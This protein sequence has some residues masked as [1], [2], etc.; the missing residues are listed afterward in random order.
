MKAGCWGK[1][2]GPNQR[3][4]GLHSLSDY[5]LN[6]YYMLHLRVTLIVVMVTKAESRVKLGQES[7][8]CYLCVISVIEGNIK[9]RTEHDDKMWVGL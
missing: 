8:L 9:G 2:F 7:G 3:V 4:L 1:Q 6:T 5:L